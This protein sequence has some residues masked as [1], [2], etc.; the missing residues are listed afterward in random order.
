MILLDTHVW[1]W[2]VSN[3]ELL[4]QQAA[5][6][7]N[8]AVLKKSV[9]ISSISVWEV[10][11]LVKRKRLRLSM[12]VNNWIAASERLPFFSFVP[13]DNKIA[14]KSVQL[15]S[16]V[17][18]DPADRIIIASSIAKGAVLVTKDKKIRAF[19]KVETLW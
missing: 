1:I 17:P 16:S 3:P 5:N 12:D 9:L 7:V 6:A 4:S 18:K 8:E 13:V 15:P 2:F 14:R 19:P 11:L 10:A